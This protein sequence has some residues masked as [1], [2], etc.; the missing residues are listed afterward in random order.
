MEAN[1]HSVGVSFEGNGCE[2]KFTRMQYISLHWLIDRLRRDGFNL[3]DHRILPITEPDYI[4]GRHVAPCHHFDW[5][6]V[7]DK[8]PNSTIPR[9]WNGSTSCW[10]KQTWLT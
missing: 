8:F 3:P 5:Y 7:K 9:S 2:H 6:G 1:A 4:H 10:D